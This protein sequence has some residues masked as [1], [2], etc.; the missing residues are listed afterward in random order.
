[1][2]FRWPRCCSNAPPPR[3]LGTCAVV[4]STGDS[5]RH[6]Y[7]TAIDGFDS[8][9]RVNNGPTKGYEKWVGSRTTHQVVHFVP[10]SGFP[11]VTPSPGKY[12]AR[13]AP[14][15]TV[16][17]TFERDA[18]TRAAYENAKVSHPN[19]QF[20]GDGWAGRCSAFL[21]RNAAPIHGENVLC[22]QEF[23]AVQWARERCNRTV[24]FGD[25]QTP[26]DDRKLHHYFS[27]PDIGKALETAKMCQNAK[28][29]EAVARGASGLS[30]RQD[31]YAEY[32]VYRD[33]RMGPHGG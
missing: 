21:F 8:V 18:R 26:C 19:W 31:F 23:N 3:G 33:P 22:S 1:M 30:G 10:V 2:P 7:G 4:L 11:W 20:V 16:G 24:V 32:R 28:R 9:I 12:F 25:G 29:D 27:I 5:L 14:P 17:L 15:Q 13:H 6:E